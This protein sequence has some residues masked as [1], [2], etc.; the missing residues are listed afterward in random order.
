MTLA[1]MQGRI[2]APAE[3]GRE[4]GD[5]GGVVSEAKALGL[6]RCRG[7]GSVL[8][9]EPEGQCVPDHGGSRDW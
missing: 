9:E 1:E 8:R 2:L 3:K 4:R 6:G 5:P 7:R